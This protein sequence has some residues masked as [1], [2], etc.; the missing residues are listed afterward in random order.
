MK[1]RTKLFE[2]SFPYPFFFRIEIPFQCG[3]LGI[4]Y[5]KNLH[6]SR[7]VKKGGKNFRIQYIYEKK[8]V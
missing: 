7:I 4:F 2:K 6:V 8:L 1:N 5:T 3:F